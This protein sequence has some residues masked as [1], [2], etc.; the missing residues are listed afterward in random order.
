MA[1]RELRNVDN[2]LD[3]SNRR[4]TIL[5]PFSDAPTPAANPAPGPRDA[6]DGTT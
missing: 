2:P 6:P 5:L 1:D 4:I 3:P